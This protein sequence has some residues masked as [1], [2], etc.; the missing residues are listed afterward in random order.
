MWISCNIQY[1]W[2]YNCLLKRWSLL[3]YFLDY[4][5]LQEERVL[6]HYNGHGVPKPTINGEIWVFNKVQTLLFNYEQCYIMWPIDAYDMTV[7][8]FNWRYTGLIPEDLKKNVPCCSWKIPL[9]FEQW[10]NK[11]YLRSLV[12]YCLSSWYIFLVLCQA[13]WL[14]LIHV[15]MARYLIDRAIRSIF[16]CPS[17]T[18]KPGWAAHRY[19]S[20]I[21]PVQA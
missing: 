3:S 1:T 6:F 20:T 12:I 11:T 10:C 16:L 4:C 19:T 21:A 7:F 8:I 5:Y 13:P 18:C 17:T 15:L 2:R 14:L 9:Q